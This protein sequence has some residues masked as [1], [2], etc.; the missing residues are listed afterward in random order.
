MTRSSQTI[1]SQPNPERFKHH[2]EYYSKS[3]HRP[4][5]RIRAGPDRLWGVEAAIR[6]EPGESAYA[7]LMGGADDGTGKTINSI[8]MTMNTEC[9]LEQTPLKAST[10]GLY[11]SPDKNSVTAW[12]GNA[13]DAL[14][15]GAVLLTPPM[16]EVR[17]PGRAP[18]GRQAVCPVG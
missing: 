2:H 17:R 3:R 6:L 1:E 15:V 7:G 14:L 5:R 18:R 8:A 10:P 4:C 13:E 11:V 16:K 9:D 12:V